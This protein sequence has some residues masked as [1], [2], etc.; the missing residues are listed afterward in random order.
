MKRQD[1]K[2]SDKSKQLMKVC[3]MVS[4]TFIC[5]NLPFAVLRLTYNTNATSFQGSI[6]VAFTFKIA[7][8]VAFCNHNV[9][10]ILYCVTGARFRAEL[11]ALFYSILNLP[12]SDQANRSMQSLS[13]QSE[14]MRVN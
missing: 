7:S 6:G 4:C 9:N 2:E 12:S 5:L 1:G 13:I 10:F 14:T 8:F 11:K 3:L